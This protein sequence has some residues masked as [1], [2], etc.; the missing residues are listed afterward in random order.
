MTTKPTLAVCLLFLLLYGCNLKKEPEEDNRDRFYKTMF[1]LEDSLGKK[2]HIRQINFDAECIYSAEDLDSLMIR[3][4]REL[5]GFAIDS[6]QHSTNP[7]DSLYRST[8]FLRGNAFTFSSSGDY[9]DLDGLMP[10][11]DSLTRKL[12]PLYAFRMA[13]P[14]YD[15]TVD[16]LYATAA[17]FKKAV[18]EGF[19]CSLEDS[20]DAWKAREVWPSR[21]YTDVRVQE[22]PSFPDL[23]AKYGQALQ[24]LHSRGYRV[25]LLTKNRIYI[26]DMF[27]EHMVDIFIDGRDISGPNKIKGNKV[28]CFGDNWGIALA[29]TLVK[30]YQGMPVVYNRNTRKHLK[31]KREAYLRAVEQVLGKR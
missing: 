2:H 19:P 14:P 11:L 8:L 5:G 28:Q 30:Y 7:D 17:D 31:Y 18:D 26:A 6:V 10:V 22:I 3:I 9:V 4:V 29:Y 27:S 23:Q 21:V 16:M 12:A 1:A 25:P 24:D 20:Y 15:Q 13:N